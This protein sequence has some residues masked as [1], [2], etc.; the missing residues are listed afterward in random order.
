[1][2]Q[3]DSG[4]YRIALCST[5]EIQIRFENQILITEDMTRLNMAL[6]FSTVFTLC[7]HPTPAQ[8]SLVKA[9]ESQSHLIGPQSLF[10]HT[11]EKYRMQQFFFFPILISFFLRCCA[12]KCISAH[13]H[14][15][16]N[17]INVRKK[18]CL[19]YSNLLAMI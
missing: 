5:N 14:H 17:I 2:H 4:R 16:R 8:L 18:Y 7:K 11:S 3:S 1:M 15:V 10:S 13:L 19:R 6:R 12:Y 9:E